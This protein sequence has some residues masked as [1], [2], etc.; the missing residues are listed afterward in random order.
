[1]KNRGINIKVVITEK[2]D[3]SGA[4]ARTGDGKSKEE[5]E[6]IEEK[7]MVEYRKTL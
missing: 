1:M 3:M 7:G 5:K 6:I 2:Q 4:A